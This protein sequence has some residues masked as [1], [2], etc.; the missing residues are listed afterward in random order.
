MQDLQKIVFV[1]S[2]MMNHDQSIII[3]LKKHHKKSG[4]KDLKSHGDCYKFE[5]FNI[6]KDRRNFFEEGRKER[7]IKLIQREFIGKNLNTKHEV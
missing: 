6:S 4:L 7:I 5:W 2:L 3:Q 1:S